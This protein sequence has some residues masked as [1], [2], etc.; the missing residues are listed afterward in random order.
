VVR[1]HS[2]L[3]ILDGDTL[4]VEVDVEQLD[5]GSITYPPVALN[6][7]RRA[8]NLYLRI[9][10]AALRQDNDGD[11]ITDIVERHLLLDPQNADSDGDGIPDGRDSLPNVPHSS[12]EDPT[13][14]AMAAVIEKM[15]DVRMGPIIEGM[16]SGEGAD[17]LAQEFKT[18]RMGRTLSM[19]HPIFIEGNAADFATLNPSRMVLVYNKQ[20]VAQ[21]QHMTPDFHAVAFAPLIVNEAKE[22]AYLVWSNGWA[23][24]TFRLVREGKKWNVFTL[25]QWIT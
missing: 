7:K 5:T 14:G 12:G 20:Q 17:R 15:F 6:S 16:D 22:R 10:I 9:P 21:L 18:I 4:N 13:Q 23:G 1:E 2:K 25:S 24:G 8:R 11:G 19:E 3:P